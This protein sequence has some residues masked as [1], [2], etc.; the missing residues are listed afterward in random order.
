MSEFV[1]ERA[2]PLSECLITSRISTSLCR[3][4]FE[5]TKVHDATLFTA[6]LKWDLSFLKDLGYSGAPATTF[7]LP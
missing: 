7:R 6:I 3:F 1:H 5:S 4:I 2:S